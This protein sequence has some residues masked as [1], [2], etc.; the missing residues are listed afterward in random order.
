MP[1]DL[2]GLQSMP[3]NYFEPVVLEQTSQSTPKLPKG[4]AL[5]FFGTIKICFKELISNLALKFLL[6]EIK[7]CN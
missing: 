1:I 5:Y 7:K 3:A 4:M 2:Y 6:K